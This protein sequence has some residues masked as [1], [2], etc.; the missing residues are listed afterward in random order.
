MGKR[1]RKTKS[2]K[3]IREENKQGATE[4]FLKYTEI[5]SIIGMPI[6]SL[7]FRPNKRKT[8]TML[9]L[10]QVFILLTY[11]FF[12]IMTHTL[13]RSM[14]SMDDTIIYLV[15]LVYVL[16]FVIII[17]IIRAIVALYAIG[18]RGYNGY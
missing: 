18:F 3:E 13:Y 12:F 11:G 5:I 6:G 4:K 7:F 9:A 15:I 14:I 16:F 17:S 2:R 8:K 1:D 10:Y